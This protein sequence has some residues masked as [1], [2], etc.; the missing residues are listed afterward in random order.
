MKVT[1]NSK[2]APLFF[3]I[4]VFVC[5]V[6]AGCNGS[7]A[8]PDPAPP[9]AAVTAL[10]PGTLFPAGIHDDLNPSSGGKIDL[11]RVVG[12]K[13]VVLCYWIAGNLR[14]EEVFRQLEALAAEVGSERLAL[15][16]VIVPRPNADAAAIAARVRS[17]GIRSPVIADHGFE[18]GQR[19]QVAH[20]PHIAVLDREGRLQLTNGASL[21]QL[22]TPDLNLAALIHRTA[23]N[24]QL[25]TYG[26]LGRYFPVKELEGSRCPDFRAPRLAD[27]VEQVWS[28]MM[29]RE[30]LN[31][32]IFWSVDCPHCRHALPEINSWLQQNPQGI[33]VVSAALITNEATRI[34]TREFCD[35]NSFVF[36]TLVDDSNLTDLFQVTTTPTI[37]FIRPDGVIDS[38]L[39]T[40]DQ[41]FAATLEQKR[42]EI[43][44]S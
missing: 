19:L 43:L 20:V 44:G 26:A 1:R 32:L 21:Q 28:R 38:A 6:A 16:G 29:D 17:L 27:S 35:L 40:A 5:S 22:L 42:R 15:Y 41:A 12:Q 25:A 18:I 11:S 4:P 13:P 23:Q 37:I 30:K 7:S 14:S 2:A 34:K 8:E 3:L 10:A 33:N 36:P 31:V 39:V 9:A 24:G